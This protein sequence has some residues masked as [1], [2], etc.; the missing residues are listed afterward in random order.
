ME[1]PDIS[2]H[3]VIVQ[4]IALH[5]ITALSFNT[6]DTFPPSLFP[7]TITSSLL[8][9]SDQDQNV[10][11]R[12][13][14][15][16]KSIV[17]VFNSPAAWIKASS[18]ETIHQQL[19][20]FA[21][22]VLTYRDPRFPQSIWKELP[23]NSARKVSRKQEWGLNIVIGVTVRVRSITNNSNLSILCF[24]K[25]TAT[26]TITFLNWRLISVGVFTCRFPLFDATSAGQIRKANSL[27]VPSQ[28]SRTAPDEIE[29]TTEGPAVPC[30][31]R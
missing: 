21:L 10:R 19:W 29:T 6:N 18:V 1:S 16:L 7:F 9:F 4:R 31:W 14:D 5:R 25:Q 12:S 23:R 13:F 15:I 24:G 2:L 27:F 17:R 30:F 26:K 28:E 20:I 22:V 11:V 3:W 8:A